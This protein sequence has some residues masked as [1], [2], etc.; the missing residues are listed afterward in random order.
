MTPGDRPLA[1]KRVVVTRAKDQAAEMISLLESRGAVVLLLPVL[2]FAASSETDLLDAVLRSLEKIDWVLFTSE[3]AARYLA[4]RAQEIGIDIRKYKAAPKIAAVGP[5][6]A[7]AAEASG[8]YVTRVARR[9]TSQDLADELQRELTGKCVL[10]PR[11]DLATD[12][13]PKAL[14]GFAAQVITVAA[15]RTVAP[16]TGKPAAGG[17]I[18]GIEEP[19]DPQREALE[20]VRRGEVDVVTFASPSSL[21]NFAE[22]VGPE[23]MR[24]LSDAGRFA[25]IGPTTSRAISDAGFQATIEA[26]DSTARGLVAAIV[27]HFEREASGAK[28]T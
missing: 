21:Q 7:G 13:L 14:R 28:A 11:S 10:L 12:E 9:H 17:R 5:A 3:N 15:Y 27:A 22:L 18:R 25:A 24:A 6:S 26:Q 1:G 8:W 16:G 2:S 23:P 20:Q 4:Q 19:R